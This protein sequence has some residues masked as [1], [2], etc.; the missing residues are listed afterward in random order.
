MKTNIIFV[1]KFRQ[2]EILM[3]LITKKLFEFRDK[4]ME[5]EHPL[6]NNYLFAVFSVF[7]AALLKFA[8]D[9]IIKSQ[10]FPFMLFL[11]AVM[12]SS[13]FGGFLPG[14]FATFISALIVDYLFLIP[15]RTL[16]FNNSFEQNLLLCLFIGLGILISWLNREVIIAMRKAKSIS[17]DLEKERD[18]LKFQA[19]ILNQV[20]DAVIAISKNKKITYWNKEAERLYELKSERPDSKQITKVVKN[21]WPKKSNEKEMFDS[22]DKYGYWDD[23]QVNLRGNGE[24]NYIDLTMTEIKNNNKKN[25]GFLAVIRDVTQRKSSEEAMHQ[26]NEKI[27]NILESITDAFCAID[28][29]GKFSYIN[30]QAEILFRKRREKLLGKTF[31]E[32]LPNFAEPLFIKKVNDFLENGIAVNFEMIC[33]KFDK[34]WFEVRFY[35]STEGLSIYFEDINHRKELE[36]RKD[37][38]VSIASHELKTPITSIK[39]YTQILK[40]KNGEAKNEKTV[41][42]LSRM[43]NQINQLIRIVDNLLD[44]SKIKTGVIEFHDEFFSLDD[45]IKEVSEDF[46]NMIGNK[47]ILVKGRIKKRIYADKDRVGQVLINLISNAIKYSPNFNKIIVSETF[48]K[49]NIIIAVKDFGIGISKENQEKVFN[50]YFRAPNLDGKKIPGFGLGLY[51]AEEIINH[52]NG[53]IWVES[54]ENKGSTFF[55]SLPVVQYKSLN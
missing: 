51:I 21:I 34:K 43:D 13:W 37:E 22:L 26:L 41:N 50:R 9:P 33:F 6:L 48:N 20:N 47:E 3:A 32:E 44:V 49:Q 4:V 52:Y 15:A 29:E 35:P 5:N 11:G 27:T 38:F 25:R 42:Y 8:S 36:Q 23:E 24:K 7:L 46:N 39:A 40:N 28:K 18:I 31:W 14:V 12:V 16:F 2:I 45:L 19:D 17:L 54:K 10:Q 30:R 1:N 55:L 53:K